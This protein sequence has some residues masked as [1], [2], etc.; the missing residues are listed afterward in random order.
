[1]GEERKKG[2]NSEGKKERE[3]RM[4]DKKRVKESKLRRMRNRK[5]S[6]ER[7]GEGGGG[8]TD[9]IQQRVTQH[10]A[11]SELFTESGTSLSL[12]RSFFSLPLFSLSFF[13]FFFVSSLSF[14][15]SNILFIAEAVSD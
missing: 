3:N 1:M 4:R 14:P 6:L 12:A 9:A 7:G 8:E 13:L 11:S 10:G 2:I 15:L 5:G